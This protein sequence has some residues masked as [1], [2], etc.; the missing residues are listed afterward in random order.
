MRLLIVEDE[1]TLAQAMCKALKVHG[2]DS[3][4]AGTVLAGGDAA[5]TQA[6]DCLVIDVMLPDGNGVE[7][8][9]WLREAGC[10]TP[11]IILTAWNEVSRRI[12]GLNAGADDYL[13]KPVDI[14]ELVARVHAV[15]RRMRGLNEI[16]H[17][18]VGSLRLY[19]QSRT[20]VTSDGRMLELSAKEFSLLEFLFRHPGQVLT[21]EQLTVHLWGMDAEVA[22][23]AL[24]NYVYFVR[25]KVA[26]LGVRDII[27]TVRGQGYMLNPA[28]RK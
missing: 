9:Q 1:T 10:T 8:V 17:L 15:V 13:G 26:K 4:Y 22:D 6:Y 14:Q 3:D 2:I 24:D 11:I 28:L 18:D 7:L 21:R 19:L 23:N 27:H 5:M 12:A 16:D 25:K 20:L